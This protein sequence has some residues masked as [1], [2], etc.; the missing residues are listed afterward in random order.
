VTA[1]LCGTITSTVSVEGS[2]APGSPVT[3]QFQPGSSIQQPY[4]DA[5]SGC[6]NIVN[7]SYVTIDGNGVGVIESTNNGSSDKYANQQAAMGIY[8]QSTSH[9]TIENLT[10]ANLYVHDEPSDSSLSS[11]SQYAI[12][13]YDGNDNTVTGNTIHDTQVG[14]YYRNDSGYGDDDSVDHNTFSNIN[15]PVNQT[16]QF[17]GG[18]TGPFYFDHNF[19]DG[20][21]NW[22][23]TADS[24]HHDGVHCYT[25]DTG[26]S[27]VHSIGNYYYDNSFIS[28]NG[29]GSD[30]T[31]FIFLESGTGSG[32][33]PCDDSSSNNY[34]FNNVL[35]DDT[36]N[37]I[38]NGVMTLA[39]GV[40]HV[41]NNT[42]VGASSAAGG[43]PLFSIDGLAGEEFENNVLTSADELVN[44]VAGS[45][46]STSPDYNVYA[47]GS[48]AGNTWN[49][50]ASW[51][52]VLSTWQSCIGRA[53]D[54]HSIYAA[55]AALNSDGSPQSGSPVLNAGANLTSLCNGDLAPLCS[56]IG[57]SSRPTS[58][59]WTAG[60]IN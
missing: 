2:G 29:N 14:V 13:D 18:S 58:G 3:L 12:E 23:T 49:C 6:L 1:G 21:A 5:S 56:D 59:S 55:S 53:G 4:C 36:T 43:P 19:A 40:N 32:S 22:D 16:Y 27:P 25:S 24:Y 31:S 33:T 9:I 37:G 47:D 7:Q 39:A 42:M 10:I 11:K 57:G 17:S 48:T 52:G 44:A 15:N 28:G 46:A 8:L 51:I 26:G 54:A 60:A 45:F 34:L 20:F 30:F 35:I 38:S 50:S 41:F